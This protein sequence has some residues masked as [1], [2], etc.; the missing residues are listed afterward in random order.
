MLYGSGILAVLFV[1]ATALPLRLGRR[2][3]ERLED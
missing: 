2:A 3:L 1:L